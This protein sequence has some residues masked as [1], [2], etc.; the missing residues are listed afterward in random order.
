M[1]DVYALLQDHKLKDESFSEELRRILTEKKK[2]R[3]LIELFGII[4]NEEGE[5]MLKD[6]E[7]IRKDNSKLMKKEAL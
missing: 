2:K 3:T 6:L 4:S 7:R 1:E 5:G